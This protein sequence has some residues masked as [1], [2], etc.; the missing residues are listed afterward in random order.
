MGGDSN[1][2]LLTSLDEAASI[3][4][5]L[6]RNI[7][8]PNQIDLAG[9]YAVTVLQK[10]LIGNAVGGAIT[11]NLPTAVGIKGM[12][13]TF[14]KSDAS[15]NPVTIAAFGAE[16]IDGTASKILAAQYGTISIES[17]GANWVV[18]VPTAST[19]GTSRE[20]YQFGRSG[21]VPGGGTLQLFASGSATTGFRMNRAGTITGGSIQ[22]NA[23]DAV[24]AYKLSIRVN[25]V[26]VALVALPVA[27]AG[28]SSAALAVAFVA[29]DRLTAFVVRTS[30]A[31]ASTFTDTVAMI[32]VTV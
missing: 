3:D 22:V 25:G 28:A 26:E 31:A 9:V 30:G 18:V 2:N 19:S 1:A 13:F 7:Q 10:T 5:V 32:E 8:T 15:A 23:A 11:Y 16:L 20:P 21:A 14:K 4:R 6:Q 24:R 12:R 27:T 29:G 17:D